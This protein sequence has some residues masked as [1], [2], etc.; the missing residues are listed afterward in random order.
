MMQDKPTIE[1]DRDQDSDTETI[2]TEITTTAP[3][4]FWGQTAVRDAIPWA[5]Q[6]FILVDTASGRVLSHTN[7]QLQ[8]EDNTDR[9]GCWHW[10][11][12]EKDGWFGFCNT[13]SGRYLG[14]NF[15]GTLQAEVTHHLGWECFATKR[16]P[17]GGYQL[18]VSVHGKLLTVGL[19]RD[20][21]LVANA[22]IKGIVWEFV[23][24]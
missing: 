18:L 2:F 19:N 9:R 7:G 24:V 6:T 4:G 8:L 17:S 1:D 22:D 11:C 16:H 21:S 12:V 14:I 15:W 13:A 5:S 10:S 3:T 23:K 20:G